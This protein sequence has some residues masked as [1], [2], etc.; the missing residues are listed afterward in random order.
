MLLEVPYSDAMNVAGVRVQAVEAQAGT[1]KREADAPA[2]CGDPII[3]RCERVSKAR[4]VEQLRAGVRDMNQ[5]KATLRT[6]MGACGGKT[7]RELILGICREEGIQL[8]EVTQFSPRPFEAE[9]PLFA[10]SGCD[11]D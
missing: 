4:I 8:A 11:T 2:S 5:L 10:L 3:C 1:G 6:G 7:C 9:L